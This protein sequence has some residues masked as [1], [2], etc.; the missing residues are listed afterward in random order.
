VLRHVPDVLDRRVTTA[1]IGGFL[2]GLVFPSV[3]SFIGLANDPRGPSLALLFQEHATSRLLWIIDLAPFVLGGTAAYVA[4]KLVHL[5]T[6]EQRVRADLQESQASVSQFLH[7]CRD[8]VVMTGAGGSITAWNPAAEQVFGYTAAEVMGQPLTVVDPPEHSFGRRSAF[9]NLTRTTDGSSA[10]VECMAKGER[11]FV[12]AASAGVLRNA[13]GKPI[14][15][16]AIVRDITEKRR[17]TEQLREARDEAE[18]ANRAKSRFLATMSHEIRTPMNG[19]IGMTE[20]L[21]DTELTA[22]QRDHLETLHASAEQLMFVINDILDFS[23]LEAG[24]MKLQHGDVDVRDL[25]HTTGGMFAAQL[26]GRAVALKVVVADDV[27]RLVVA[28]SHRLRQVLTNLIG[29]AVKFTERGEIAVRARLSRQVRDD[30]LLSFEIEDSGIGLSED[31]QK[32]LFMAF[33]QADSSNTRRA[34]GTG[35]GLAICKQLVGLM[36]GEIGVDSRVGRGS[37]FWFTVRA[38][39]ATVKHGEAPTMVISPPPER[40]SDKDAVEGCRIL[41]VDDN[42]VNQKVATALLRSMGCKVE[43]VSNGREA[44]TACHN[45]TYEIVLMDVHMPVVDGFQATA[46]IRQLTRGAT[47]P[48]VAMTARATDSDRADCLAAGMDDHIAK[49]FRKEDLLAVLV[50]WRG[51]TSEHAYPARAG[52]AATLPRSSAAAPA[53]Q[54][55]EAVT[56]PAFDSKSL[57]YLLTAAGPG[58][59]AL[60]EEIVNDF[61]HDAPADCAVLQ[62]HAVEGNA[63]GVRDVA[64]RLRSSTGNVGALEMSSLCRQIEERAREGDLANAIEW[65][66]AVGASLVRTREALREHVTRVA[67]A[68]A[69]PASSEPPASSSAA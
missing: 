19:V 18:A 50:K 57:D 5:A 30:V 38:R 32:K 39:I 61:L 7:T 23:K 41:L 35:L 49:P 52:T 59:A 2:F 42:V 20:I 31:D 17:A 58:G 60:I 1:G 3:A 24:R 10:E 40:V 68:A 55:K 64:H 28:D 13:E 16:I 46:E 21:L 12:A 15:L 53:S 33:S 66:E 27:P 51:R 54:P 63:A 37:T 43:V 34:G 14:G 47:V 45:P 6:A 56:A 62:R 8:A 29:N 4:W 65:A 22:D 48:I 67:A 26:N 25:L 9:S 11:R 44:V 36:E 69:A